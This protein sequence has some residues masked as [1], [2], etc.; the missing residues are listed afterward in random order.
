MTYAEMRKEVSRRINGA[1]IERERI[2]RECAEFNAW[3]GGVPFPFPAEGTAEVFEINR[4]GTDD[5]A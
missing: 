4:I 5:Y 3:F 1:A 2:E